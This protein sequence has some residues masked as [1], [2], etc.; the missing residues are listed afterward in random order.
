MTWAVDLDGVVWLAGEALPGAAEAVE[1][2]RRA[3]DRVVFLT[4]NSGPRLAGHLA[5]LA[6]VGIRCEAGD[7]VTSAEAAASL[8]SP[9]SRVAVVGDEGIYEALAERSVEVVAPHDSPSAVVV[10]R[11]VELDYDE[12]AAAAGAVRAGARFVATN[13]DA[14]FPT[15]DGLLP[16]AGALVAFLAT[17]SGREPEVAGKPHEAM[18]NLVRRRYGQVEVMAG[19]RPDTDGL[20]AK[21]LGA[22]FGL[23]FSG[24]TRRDDL[25][26]EPAPDLV[27]DDLAGLVREYV[28]RPH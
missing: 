8:I 7:L 3:G 15:G 14:T 20:F 12:L 17:A 18:A 4:N 5:K 19:D 2:L 21:R 23:V 13:T 24:V 1:Q 28:R 27:A 22:R 26:V 6:A 25:P 9:G 16:G 10:G 11:T